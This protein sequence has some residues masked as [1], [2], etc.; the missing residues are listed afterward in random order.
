VECTPETITV[1]GFTV[2]TDA[3]T[4]CDGRCIG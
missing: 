1:N 4:N 3:V 2:T